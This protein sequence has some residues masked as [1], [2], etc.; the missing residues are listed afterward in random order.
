VTAQ[1]R[2]KRVVEK[3]KCKQAVSKLKKFATLR[4]NTN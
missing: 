1:G 4:A 3:N 2:K